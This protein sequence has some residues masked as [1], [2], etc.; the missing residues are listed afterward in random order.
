[1]SRCSVVIIVTVKVNRTLTSRNSNV[2]VIRW[3]GFNILSQDF[4]GGPVVKMPLFH[5][6]GHGFDPW[7]GN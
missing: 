3:E 6:K 1:M 2:P 7:S 4:P 5:C